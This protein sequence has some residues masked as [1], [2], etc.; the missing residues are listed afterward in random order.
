LKEAIVTFQALEAHLSWT[1][2][3]EY[4]IVTDYGQTFYESF[5]EDLTSASDKIN[6]VLEKS[7]KERKK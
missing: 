5:V 3:Q 6:S 7:M 2:T 4:K 1:K